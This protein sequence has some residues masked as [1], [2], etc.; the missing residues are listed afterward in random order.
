MATHEEDLM[1]MIQ[2]RLSDVSTATFATANIH[3]AL[4]EKLHD[5]AE[6]VPNLVLSTVTTQEG[7][8]MINIGAQ[9]LLLYGENEMSF[10]SV[11]F[12][13]DAD[14][15][16][17]RNFSVEGSALYMDIDFL[18][19][20]GEEVRLTL[21]K[22]HLCTGSVAASLTLSP[23]LEQII[24]PYVAGQVAID[25]AVDSIGGISIGGQR[26]SEQFEAWGQRT[27]ERAERDLTR[28]SKA[29]MS[30]EYPRDR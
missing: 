15:R 11:E 21:R 7:T 26:T 6:Y 12:P 25:F 24:I 3:L 8:A 13:T 20:V 23:K 1:V 4:N 9:T 16:R 17:L 30:I 29:R 22:A 10:E 14:P 27:V 18:P 2:R 19:S 5:I 28:M